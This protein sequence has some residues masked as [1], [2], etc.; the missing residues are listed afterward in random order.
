M[1]HS[2][3]YAT[4]ADTKATRYEVFKANLDKIDNFNKVFDDWGIFSLS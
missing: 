3:P 1:Q 4:D 2:K